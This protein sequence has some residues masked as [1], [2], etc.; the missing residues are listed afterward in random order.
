LKIIWDQLDVSELGNRWLLDEHRSIHAYFKM[1]KRLWKHNPILSH[2]PDWMLE[3]HKKQV[4][5]IRKRGYDHSSPIS[6]EDYRQ[7]KKMWKSRWIN[8]V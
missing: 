3:R 7:A 5:E 8:E 2:N 6:E 1:W 4:E